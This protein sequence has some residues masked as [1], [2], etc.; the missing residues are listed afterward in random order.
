MQELKSEFQYEAWQHYE[1]R[2]HFFNILK[3]EIPSINFPKSWEIEIIPPRQALIRFLVTHKNQVNK[4]NYVSVYLDSN[5][6]LGSFGE[7]YW[8]IFPYKD[9]DTR[10]FLLHETKEMIKAIKKTL[11]RIRLNDLER[12]QKE[13]LNAKS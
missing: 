13:Q 8:E 10:R 7:P 12:A 1:Q 9:V 2:E 5:N 3:L 6:T 11:L 4:T